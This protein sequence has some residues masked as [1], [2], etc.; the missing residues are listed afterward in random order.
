VAIVLGG[1]VLALLFRNAFVAAHRQIGWAL[2]CIFVAALVGPFADLLDRKMP[3]WLAL[4]LTMLTLAVMTVV[5][6]AAIIVN[7]QDGLSTLSK[8]APLAASSLEKRST[9]AR[10]FRLVERVNSLIDNLRSSS[11]S[12]TMGHAVGAAGT[13]FVCGILTLFFLIYGPRILR[14]AFAQV[15]DVRRRARIETRTM[16]ALANGRRY[17]I[18]AIAQT[19]VVSAVVGLTAWALALPA[20]F[21]LGALAGTVGLIPTLGIVVGGL[22]ALLI[23]AGLKG[24]RDSVIVV[25]VA[26]QVCCESTARDACMLNFKTLMI[27]DACATDSDELHNASLN[28]FYQNFGDVQS[29]DEVIASLQRGLEAQKAVA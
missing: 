21:V 5:V 7:L 29:V 17:I 16:Q 26:T 23:A 13:Y 18:A 15:K 12:S 27:S 22:P 4:L 14:A 1:C 24:W 19:I 2:A 20:P 28:A 3:K 10:E 25:G 11:K 8:E 6:W 9:V